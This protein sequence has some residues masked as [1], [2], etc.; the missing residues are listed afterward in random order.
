ML[1]PRLG[2]P[3]PK[4]EPRLGPPGPKLEPRLGPPGPKRFINSPQHSV[5]TYIDQNASMM[6]RDDYQ[7][8]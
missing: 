7:T 3:G 8:K 4:L 1:E 6:T 2:P 5:P